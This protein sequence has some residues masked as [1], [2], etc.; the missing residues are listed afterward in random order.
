[1]KLSFNVACSCFFEESALCLEMF[2]FD[3][4]L[5]SGFGEAFYSFFVVCTVLVDRVL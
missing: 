5:L 4:W 2:L 3:S 1:M